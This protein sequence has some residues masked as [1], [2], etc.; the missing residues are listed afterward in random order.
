MR[1]N[2]AVRV[3]RKLVSS[4]LRRCCEK[5]SSI[6][7]RDCSVEEEHLVKNM[8]ITSWGTNIGVR[9]AA[10]R[11]PSPSLPESLLDTVRHARK[12]RRRF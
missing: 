11:I 9:Y 7:R 12:R 3:E 4:R 5:V 8:S 10:R 6:K 2:T 1:V